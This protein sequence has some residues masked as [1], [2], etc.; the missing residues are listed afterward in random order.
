MAWT[1]GGITLPVTPTR[2][3]VEYSTYTNEIKYPS[4]RALVIA[5]GRQ[6]DKM[7]IEGSF[8]DKNKTQAEMSQDYLEAFRDLVGTMVTVNDGRAQD[9][10]DPA[11]DE[12][13]LLISF[14][15]IEE[16]GYVQSFRYTMELIQGDVHEVI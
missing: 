7:R 4:N 16:G 11:G 9:V 12:D 2:V 3:T 6:V 13:W 1:I 14:R 10:Y 15:F 8:V 5:L